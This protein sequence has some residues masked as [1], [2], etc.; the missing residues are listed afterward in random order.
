MLNIIVVGGGMIGAATA[1]GLLRQGHR[2]TLIEQH[3]PEAFAPEQ[4]PDIRMSALS[5]NS[6][7]LLDS[8]GAWSAI[9]NMRYQPYSRLTVFENARDEDAKTHFDAASIQQQWLGYFVENRITQ[10]GLHAVLQE[11]A[12]NLTWVTDSR[13]KAINVQTGQVT[14]DNM[15]HLQADWIIGADGSNSQVRQLAGIGQ[16]GWQYG[17]QAMGIIVKTPFTATHETWQQFRPQGPIAYLPMYGSYAALIWYDQPATLEQLL[18]LSDDGLLAQVGATFGAQ[19]NESVLINK[20]RFPLTRS[21]ANEYVKGRVV[22]IGDAAHTINPLAGQGVNIGF[23]D[24][25]T[26]LQ[27]F[28]THHEPSNAALINQYQRPRRWANALMMTTMDAFYMG[29]SNDNPVLKLARN[30]ALK[31]ADNAGVLKQQVLKY[32]VGL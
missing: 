29:F 5:L 27:V 14:L 12:S 28:A 21:H 1:L 17:Q 4:E 23:K 18:K 13:I 19:F 2:V 10:L 31:V 15:E 6:V 7:H 22:L 3:L 30:A 11:F 20:A 16:T 8:L 24:V 32:A 25:E 9:Q 26:L